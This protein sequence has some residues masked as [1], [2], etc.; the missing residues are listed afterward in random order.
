MRLRANCRVHFETLTRIGAAVGLVGALACGG[1]TK[2]I[3]PA[4]IGQPAPPYTATTLEGAPVA[5][6]DLKGDVVLLNVWATWCKPCREEIPALDSLHRE[7]GARGLTVAGVSI[8]VIGDTVSI[9][10]FARALGATYTLWLDPDDRVS[11]TFRAIGVP[12]SYLIDRDGVLRWRAL[13]AIHA[14]DP[15]L[16]ALLDSALGPALSPALSG[17]LPRAPGAAPGA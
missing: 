17:A 4:T 10:N 6:A 2:T 11:N 9:A 1:D 14:S 5:L 8:D 12:S 15:K 7:F 13:G 16:R 3:A